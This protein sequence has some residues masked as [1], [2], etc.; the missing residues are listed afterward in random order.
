[1]N[2]KECRRKR[3]WLNLRLYAGKAEENHEKP[4]LEKLVF[5][6]RFEPRTSKIGS[7]SVN[8]STTMFRHNEFY[9]SMLPSAHFSVTWFA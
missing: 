7:R 1:M 3:P 5:D 6:P 4:Q 8:H 9:S 2:W